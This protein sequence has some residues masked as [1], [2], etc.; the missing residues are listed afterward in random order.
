MDYPFA[1]SKQL[2]AN[3]AAESEK[4]E[5][6]LDQQIGRL[7]TFKQIGAPAPPANVRIRK[8]TVFLFWIGLALA[9]LTS[10]SF[11]FLAGFH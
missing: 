9:C 11:G 8:A 10:F 4:L 6:A 5:Q 2:A 1:N 3:L 7:G